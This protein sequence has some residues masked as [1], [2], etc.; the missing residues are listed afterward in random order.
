MMESDDWIRDE[1]L[2]IINNPDRDYDIEP[3]TQK[4]LMALVVGLTERIGSPYTDDDTAIKLIGILHVIKQHV[5]M[6]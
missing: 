4:E 1:L 3:L 6:H 5:V 2:S